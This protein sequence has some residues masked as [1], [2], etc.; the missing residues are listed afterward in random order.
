MIGRAITAV[1]VVGVRVCLRTMWRFLDALTQKACAR[2][3]ASMDAAWN[4]ALWPQ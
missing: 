2:H 4:A 1:Y 3:V